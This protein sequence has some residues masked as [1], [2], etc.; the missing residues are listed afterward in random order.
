MRPQKKKLVYV[1]AD[2]DVDVYDY[3]SDEEVAVSPRGYVS[4][5]RKYHY[6]DSRNYLGT[7]IN[8]FFHLCFFLIVVYSTIYPNNG[9][10]GIRFTGSLPASI[11]TSANQVIDYASKLSKNGTTRISHKNSNNTDGDLVLDDFES[12]SGNEDDGDLVEK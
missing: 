4:K 2:D 6:D 10:L 3:E 9:V 8:Q 1:P 11:I 5:S 7:R 12:G